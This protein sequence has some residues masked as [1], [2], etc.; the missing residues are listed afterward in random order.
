[1]SWTIYRHTKGMHYLGLGL[2]LHSETRAPHTVYRCLYS[3][4]LSKTWI[5]PREMFEGRNEKGETRFEPIARL[6]VVDPEDEPVVL[7]FGFDAWGE[8]RTLNQFI[9][10]YG[11]DQ[12]HLRGTR[13]LLENLSGLPLCNLNTLRFQ[14]G[15]MGIASVAT[16]PEHRG[17]GYA[18]LLLKAVMELKRLESGD[19]VRFLLFSEVNPRIYEDCAFRVLSNEHQNFK[20]SMAMA[21]GPLPI[22]PHEGEFLKHYF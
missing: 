20:P 8:G 4:D 2:A 19:D 6:R 17:Q 12:N 9:E 7:G 5:R 14:R 16:S 15:L 3:N 22:A 11:K 1:M 10:S 18:R 13:Y 21:T